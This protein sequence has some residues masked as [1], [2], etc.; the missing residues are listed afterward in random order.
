VRPIAGWDEAVGWRP[1]DET[2]PARGEPAPG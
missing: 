2:S 1:L